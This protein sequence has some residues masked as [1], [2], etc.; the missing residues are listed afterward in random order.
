MTDDTMS[1]HGEGRAGIFIRQDYPH[2][3]PWIDAS[4]EL[5]NTTWGTFP[6]SGSPTM[7]TVGLEQ[8]I[9]ALTQEVRELKQLIYHMSQQLRSLRGVE[10]EDT[11]EILDLPP[12]S[13]RRVNAQVRKYDE[14]VRFQIIEET[15]VTESEDT[16]E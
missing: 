11:S 15:E 10:S 6:G 12:L 9:S 4:V 2:A 8:R 16:E 14:P 3:E 5:H 13:R 7:A 1:V